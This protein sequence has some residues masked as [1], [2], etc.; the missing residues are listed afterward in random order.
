M[1][2]IEHLSDRMLIE[3]AADVQ[4]QLEKG[5]AV[6][7]VLYMLDRARARARTA[8]D[9]F[10]DIDPVDTDAVRKLQNEVRLFNDMVEACREMLTAGKEAE[11]RIEDDSRDELEEIIADMP[12]EQRRLHGL[13][14]GSKD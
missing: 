1:E 7:P 5:T 2:V 14:A 11:R 10:I 9:L 8:I 13:E 3:R 6:R 4:V 12:P